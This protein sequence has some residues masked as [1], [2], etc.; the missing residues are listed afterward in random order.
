MRKRRLPKG[1]TKLFEDE[2]KITIK[3]EPKPMEK[4]FC[5]FCLYE[6]YLCKFEVKT[7]NGYSSK[8]AKCPDC[9]QG[10]RMETLTKRMT[11]V[12]LAQFLYD[13]QLYGGREKISWDKFKVRL[14][15]LGIANTFWAAWKKYRDEHFKK[16]Y[17]ISYEEFL[18]GEF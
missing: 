17:G 8:K 9:G 3:I 16:I 11:P 7:K 6:D 18:K 1:Q 12:E 15:N 5:P 4:Y 10:M 14:R 13:Y 2:P